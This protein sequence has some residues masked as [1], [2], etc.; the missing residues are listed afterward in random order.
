VATVFDHGNSVNSAAETFVKWLAQPAQGAYLTA[1]SSGL[2]SS[3]DQLT[4]P[5]VKQEEAS[6]PAY[7]V[8]A[9]QLNTGESRPTIPAYTAISQDLATE[10][11]AALTGSVSPA[12]ALA[13]AAAEGNAAIASGGSGS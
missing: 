6:Q 7:P 2:P 13:K 10:I 3:P 11:N 1:A 4:Q 8:F 12:A 9:G 5:A